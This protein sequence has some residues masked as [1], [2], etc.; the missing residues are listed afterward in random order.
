MKLP[1]LPK[2]KSSAKP[3]SAAKP[4][5]RVPRALEDLYRDMRD[6]RMI[7]PAVALI[8][9]IIAVPVALKAPKED[10]PA[11]AAFVAP[12]G[13]EAVAPAVLTEQPIGVRDYRERLDELKSKNPFTD[14]FAFP[15]DGAPSG[16]LVDPAS[17]PVDANASLGS[18][19]DVGGS[20]VSSSDAG[21]ATDS[22]TS[23][24][25]PPTDTGGGGS[26]D[27]EDDS[28]ILILAPRID[29]SAGPVGNRKD[30]NDVEIGDLLPDRRKAPVVIFLGAT[31]SLKSATFLVSD[32]VTET[33][34][35]G[36]CQPRANDC[37]FLRLAQG[38]KRSFV[39]EP[40]GRRYVVKVKDIREEVVD[41][42]KVKTG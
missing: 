36:S 22:S 23:T 9:A 10:P 26:G 25:S 8:V 28:E 20:D 12:E 14:R 18:G 15:G 42:R 31:D 19:T 11:A 13:S 35:D 17:V 34:G 6:R 30:I 40:T 24:T 41:R 5:V 4:A 27:G 1:S 32:D 2:P 39:Y 16:E 7:I 33:A 3:K 29:V 21:T 37:E 38:E